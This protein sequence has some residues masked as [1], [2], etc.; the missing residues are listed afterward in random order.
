MIVI[1]YINLC[2]N[3][4]YFIITCE[5]KCN[6]DVFIPKSALCTINNI[7]LCKK[8][9]SFGARDIFFL[10]TCWLFL[11]VTYRI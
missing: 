3:V 11:C 7:F 5:K 4:L 1:D 10:L 8:K 6:F 2:T 9:I